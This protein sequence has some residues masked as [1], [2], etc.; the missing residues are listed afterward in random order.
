MRVVFPNF[1]GGELTTLRS[2]GKTQVFSGKVN[3]TLQ[4]AAKIICGSLNKL[5]RDGVAISAPWPQD[6]LLEFGLTYLHI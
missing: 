3:L 6:L 2:I 1:L 4:A 5:A